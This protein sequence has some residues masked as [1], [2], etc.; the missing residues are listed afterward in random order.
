MKWSNK[1][2]YGAGCISIP[3]LGTGGASPRK[4]RCLHSLGMTLGAVI[5]RQ[6]WNLIEILVNK[7]LDMSFMMLE[8]P[9]TMIIDCTID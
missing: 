2:T 1:F 5:R 8:I 7:S 9:V 6:P 4:S 3:R